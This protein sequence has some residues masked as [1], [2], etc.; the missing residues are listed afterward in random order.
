MAR[1]RK[2]RLEPPALGQIARLVGKAVST[3]EERFCAATVGRLSAATRSRLDDLRAEDAGTD[4]D[5]AGGGLAGAA[6]EGVPLR[7]AGSGGPGAVHAA[8]DTVSCAPDGDHR[9]AGGA[10]HPARAED[11]HAGG[12]EGRGRVR[13]G[14][15]A[16]PRQGGHLAAAGGLYWHVE[17]K[18][19]CVYSQ[20]KSCSASE[21][22]AMIE[23]VLRHC[24]D[25]EIDRQYTDTHGA[26]IVGFASPTC[27]A[28]T[29]CPG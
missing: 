23:S 4:A 7:P 26:S 22:A 14:A 1:C 16:G 3:F 13:Q 17:K 29:C 19:L 18:S 10:V 20:L 8:V 2:D 5:S 21:V 9:L 11:Q 12:E 28:S 25:V 27:S 6:G 24:T 15:Q